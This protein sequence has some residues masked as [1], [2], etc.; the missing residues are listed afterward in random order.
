MFE[1]DAGAP[2]RLRI[3]I[4]GITNAADA[5]A[6]IESG[7]DALGFNCYAQSKRYLDLQA[8][9]PWIS[10]LPAGVRKVAV[11]VDPGWEEALAI[12]RLPF[13][14]ALQLHG[15]ERPDFC[16][17]LAAEGVRFGKA[18]PATTGGLF[19]DAPHFSTST[20]VLDSASGSLFGGTGK[21]FPWEIARE[22]VVTHPALRVILAGGLCVENVSEAVKKVRPFAVDVTTGVESSP[23]RKDHQL[24]R[25]FIAAARAA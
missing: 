12:A 3:K 4:C 7:A 5:R 8:A 24:M 16:A 15:H 2:G 1:G 9:A 18:L 23:A 14:D 13:I 10:A 19:Q 11:V 22:L 17:R 21:T 6:A 25:A 20:I